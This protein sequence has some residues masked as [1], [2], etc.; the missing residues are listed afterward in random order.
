MVLKLTKDD[1]RAHVEALREF[2][3]DVVDTFAQSRVQR[4][5]WRQK[6]G[7]KRA[8]RSLCSTV[9]ACEQPR[10]ATLICDEEPVVQGASVKE[11]LLPLGTA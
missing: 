7:C 2:F 1:L 10:R 3:F 6:L 8:G 11:T 9:T 5:C 4:R